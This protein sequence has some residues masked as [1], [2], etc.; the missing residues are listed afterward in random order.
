HIRPQPYNLLE[1]RAAILSDPDYLGIRGDQGAERL[2]DEGLFVSDKDARSLHRPS[3]RKETSAA[4]VE[5]THGGK[6]LCIRKRSV[7]VTPQ[8]CHAAG[9]KYV[10]TIV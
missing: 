8:K 10:T 9:R 7:D 2:D 3:D 5:T 6:A 4:G 1:Q